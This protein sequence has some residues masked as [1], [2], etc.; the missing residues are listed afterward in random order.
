MY[1]R[2]YLF[3]LESVLGAGSLALALVT[4]VWKDWIEI[5]FGVDPDQ[6]SGSFE[7][8]VVAVLLALALICGIAAVIEWRRLHPA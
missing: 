3:T 6:G 5:V 8:L 4:L 7:W 2:K 1:R